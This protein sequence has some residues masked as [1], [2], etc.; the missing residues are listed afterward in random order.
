MAWNTHPGGERGRVGVDARRFHARRVFWG[1]WSNKEKGMQLRPWFYPWSLLARYIPKDATI[2]A[3][4]QPDG[5]RVLA[6][7]S[8]DGWTVCVVNRRAEPVTV[9][10][11]LPGD[12]SGVFEH[13]VYA[14]DVRPVDDNGF[15]VAVERLTIAQEDPVTVT[16][17][18]EAVSVVSSMAF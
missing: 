1:L 10:V 16:V 18:S 7:K 15:P 4:E 9:P 5:V 2:Y 11:R 6:A 3:P 17:P 14:E 13:Y 8:G 12:A